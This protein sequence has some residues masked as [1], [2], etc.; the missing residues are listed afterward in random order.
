MAGIVQGVVVQITK[1]VSLSKIPL[2]SLTWNFT[3]IVGLL[4]SWYSI[5]ASANA[6]SLDGDQYTG[7]NPL[8]IKPSIAILANTSI[9]LASN[10]GVKVKYGCL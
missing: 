7:F 1:Y 5:S 3:K 2:P 10:S 4:I 8:K 9:W 6:D